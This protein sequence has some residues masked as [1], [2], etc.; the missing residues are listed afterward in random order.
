MIKIYCNGVWISF[1]LSIPHYFNLNN[2]I[3]M[4][5]LFEKGIY[6]VI[7]SFLFKNILDI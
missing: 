4:K 5:K 3:C 1:R 7:G 6:I 2:D